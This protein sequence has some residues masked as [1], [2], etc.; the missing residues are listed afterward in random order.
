MVMRDMWQRVMC[1]PDFGRTLLE[2]RARR[3]RRSAKGVC[4]K[5]IV[6]LVAVLGMGQCEA[7]GG[8]C[9]SK[10]RIV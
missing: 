10:G 5:K 8:R 6:Q 7:W 9:Y 4:N 3:L 1:D 2:V